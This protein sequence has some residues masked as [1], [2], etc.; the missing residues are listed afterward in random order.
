MRSLLVLIFL[1]TAG[2]TRMLAERIVRAPNLDAPAAS[3]GDASPQVLAKFYVDRQLRIPVGPPDAYVSVWV[4]EPF[5]GREDLRFTGFGRQVGAELHRYPGGKTVPPRATIFVLHGILDNK[6][7]GPYALFREQLVQLGYRVVQLDFRGHGRST[8]QWITYGAVESHDLVQVLDALKAQH[9]IAGEVGAIGISY[10]GATAIQWA[11]I[12][13]RV[14]AV[15]AIEPYTSFR[16]IA[17]DG[18]AFVLGPGRWLFTDA[19]IN[20]CVDLAGELA[21]FNPDDANT[22]R[23]ITKTRAPVLLIHSRDDEFI[24]WMHSQR[25]HDAAKDHSKL[26]LIDGSSHFDIWLNAFDLIRV[27]S[28][29]WFAEKLG[30]NGGNGQE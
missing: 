11:G 17:R 19:N 16:D 22:L 10:G 23:A 12:D 5:I 6:E 21:H 29:A 14:K 20:K 30:T 24:P 1:L 26:I 27:Q 9:L 28:S 25:L 15:V 7:L 4:F 3:R 8:G 13:P 2:C 18:A